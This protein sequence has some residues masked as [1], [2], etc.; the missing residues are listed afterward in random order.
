MNWAPELVVEQN[1][2]DQLENKQEELMTEEIHEEIE[3]QV[4]AEIEESVETIEQ[5][6]KDQLDNTIEAINNDNLD[7]VAE[8]RKLYD[9]KTKLEIENAKLERENEMLKEVMREEEKKNFDKYRNS[10]Q[11]LPEDRLTIKTLYE[12]KKSK[13]DEN[14]KKFIRECSYTLADSFEDFDTMLF[15]KSFTGE[16]VVEQVKQV[17]TSNTEK[18]EE[19]KIVK[20]MPFARKSSY[21]A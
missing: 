14:K 3:E 12:Y 1:V 2:I 17:E 6:N 8:F 18:K 9:E 19:P 11:V 13:T 5:D 10:V 21:E 20:A 4:N 15:K 7:V 16:V